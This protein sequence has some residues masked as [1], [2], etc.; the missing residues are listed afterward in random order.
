[1]MCVCVFCEG[2]IFNW[3]ALVL[4]ELCLLLGSLD[5]CCEWIYMCVCVWIAFFQKGVTPACIASLQGEHKCLEL[6]IKAKADVNKA[7]KV[8]GEDQHTSTTSL[9]LFLFALVLCCVVCVE[10]KSSLSVCGFTSFRHVC[11]CVFVCVCEHVC[12][13]MFYV[14]LFVF[15]VCLFGVVC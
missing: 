12:V 10:L 9:L 6:L 2:F 14:L 5:M 11:M 8:R 3:T 13:L 4:F 1:M 7:N 15:R